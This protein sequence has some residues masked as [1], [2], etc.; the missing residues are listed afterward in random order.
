MGPAPWDGGVANPTEKRSIRTCVTV[1]NLVAL[2]H[3]VWAFR[4]CWRLAPVWWGRSWLQETRFSTTCVIV[5]NSVI[6]YERNNG[7]PPEKFDPLGPPFK[8]TQGHW[9]WHRE[10]GNLWLP[11]IVIHSNHELISYTVFEIWDKRRFLST[12]ANSSKPPCLILL[13]KEFSLEFRNDGSAQ[14]VGSCT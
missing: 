8:V 13:L 12:T 11:V 3:T 4:Q 5:P 14:K 1:S 2:G 7:K 6:P 10:I 9:I